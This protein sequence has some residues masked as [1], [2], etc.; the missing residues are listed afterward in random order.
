MAA[1]DDTFGG[2]RDWWRSVPLVLTLGKKLVNEARSAQT[3][4]LQSFQATPRTT[5]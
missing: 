4:R 5:G 1:N 2:G 3:G